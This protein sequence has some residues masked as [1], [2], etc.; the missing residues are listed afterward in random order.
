MKLGCPPCAPATWVSTF[1]TNGVIPIQSGRLPLSLI[2]R[3]AKTPEAS[4]SFALKGHTITAQGNA[5]GIGKSRGSGNRSPNIHTIN[6]ISHRIEIAPSGLALPRH[7][8]F[9]RAVPWAGMSRPFRAGVARGF[10]LM[11]PKAKDFLSTPTKVGAATFSTPTK[12]GAA[13]P[14]LTNAPEASPLQRRG[15]RQGGVGSGEPP[16]TRRFPLAPEGSDPEI[17]KWVRFRGCPQPTPPPPPERGSRA[18]SQRTK[19]EDDAEG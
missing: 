2:P 1:P 16:N 17:R 15:A 9:P 7:G 10:G 14:I 11:M 3:P 8:S 18:R 6:N 19:A 13:T 5:L 4:P 12:V